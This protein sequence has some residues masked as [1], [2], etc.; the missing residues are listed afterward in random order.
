MSRRSLIA[1]LAPPTSILHRGYQM[2][3]QRD[4]SPPPAQS[5]G[6]PEYSPAA[7]PRS[8]QTECVHKSAVRISRRCQ[9]GCRPAPSDSASSAATAPFPHS[10][11]WSLAALPTRGISVV[12]SGPRS[13]AISVCAFIGCDAANSHRM[14]DRTS[15]AAT[16]DTAAARSRSL[17]PDTSYCRHSSTSPRESIPID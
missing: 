4:D 11:R 6:R 14:G 13:T 2:R 3:A 7:G 17:P 9:A 15:V 1:M 5:A 12:A 8:S 16:G 10:Q